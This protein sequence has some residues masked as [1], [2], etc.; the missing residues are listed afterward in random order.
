MSLLCDAQKCYFKNL[1]GFA[2]PV[3]DISMVIGM[4]FKGFRNVLILCFI[5]LFLILKDN[6]CQSLFWWQYGH[7][8]I[9]VES[10]ISLRLVI[11]WLHI[12]FSSLEN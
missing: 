3:M 4:D 8:K 1:G 12:L 6:L 11:L 9:P 10:N 2:D 7:H 5:Y